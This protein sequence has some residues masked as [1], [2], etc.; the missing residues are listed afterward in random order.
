MKENEI[1]FI[2]RGLV[3]DIYNELGPGLYEKVYEEIL[4]HELRKK[5]L[6]VES[7]KV[8]P[9]IW[10]NH[11]ME[12]GYRAD[13]IVEKKVI[14]EVKSIQS[15]AKVHYKQLATY[16]KLSGLKLGLLINFFEDDITKGIKRY[17]NGHIE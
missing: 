16:V 14:I 3:F 13:L 2:V 1:S 4:L 15:I 9:V 5:G 6:F 10:D 11:K 12:H 7:Q 8:I 17:I